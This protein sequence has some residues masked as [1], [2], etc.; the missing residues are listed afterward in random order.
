VESKTPKQVAKLRI[1]DP[2]CGS[3]SFL[4]N[5]YQFLLDWYHDWYLAHKLRSWAKGRNPVL[6]QTTSGWKLTIAE[7][8]RIL[9]DN[10]YGVDIDPQAVEVTKLSLM[11]KVLEG[12]SEQT[13]QPF[14]RLF[15]QRALPDLGDNIKCGNSLIG[16]DFYQQQNLPLINDDERLRINVFDWNNEYPETMKS[17]GFDA[18]IGNPPYIRIQRIDHIQSDY[19]Y[20]SF[21]TPMSKTDLSQLFLEKSFSLVKIKSL[22]GFVCSSQWMST[23]YGMNMRKMLSKGKL[24]S[25]VD[26]G[27]LPVFKKANTYPAIFILS[28]TPSDSLSIKR[29]NS[30][31]QLNIYSIEQIETRKISLHLLSESPWSFES[32]N[33]QARLRERAIEFSPLKEFGK[34]MIGDL[35]GMDAAFVLYRDKAIKAKFEKDVLY[36]YAYR[37]NEI[38]RYEYVHPKSVVIYPYKESINGHPELIPESIIRKQF[39]KIYEHLVNFKDQL[40][41][42]KDSRRLYATGSDWYRHLRPGT[43]N[44]IHPIKL[45]VRGIGIKM[46]VGLL[47][48]NTIFNGANCPCIIPANFGE[49]SYFYFLGI[50]NSKLVSWHLRSFC[51]P[52]LGGYTRFTAK[53]ISEIPIRKIDF[54]CLSDKKSH[55]LM[56]AHVEQVIQLHKLATQTKTPH[57][58]EALQRQID[59]MDKQIDQLVYQLYGLNS[60][61]IGVIEET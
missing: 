60:E 61:E 36:P 50:L 23:D 39:P 43:F 51:P 29:I 1:L 14:L 2:A 17:G 37:G 46:N 7:R 8:K 32:F 25:I 28:P 48:E 57:E 54:S 45:A 19:F 31:D 41:Q 59:A 21:K 18:V 26:F 42:R 52:K 24:R 30:S 33:L 22:M 58:E 6:V 34:A 53:N 12:E 40:R 15:Q 38:N 5:A 35:T 16:P 47:P 27:S 55:N 44:L 56:V 49:Y 13:I 4:I 10:I 9:L 20:K 3:G 11:L